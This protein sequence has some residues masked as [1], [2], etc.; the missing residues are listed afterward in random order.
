[1]FEIISMEMSL[2]P[3]LLSSLA[4]YLFFVVAL[5]I[6]VRWL[7]PRYT[8][9]RPFVSVVVAARNEE[10]SLPRLLDALIQQTYERFEVV[11]VN[12]RSTDKT[13]EIVRQYA[14][15]DS[16]ITLVNIEQRSQEMPPK[17]HAITQGILASR[18]E[19]LC[20]TDADCLPTREWVESLVRSFDDK[21]G[22]VVGYSLYDSHLTAIED[23]AIGLKGIL[24]RFLH[25]FVLYEAKKVAAL[26]AGSTGLG[27][28]WL[29]KASNLAYRKNVWEE[30]GGFE[31]LREVMSG[32][33]DL[34]LQ[35]VVRLT[36]WEVAHATSPESI[37][38]TAPVSTFTDFIAQRKRHFSVGTRYPIYIQALIALYHASNVALYASMI[39][40]VLS[41]DGVLLGIGAFGAKLFADSLLFLLATPQFR[42]RR[43]LPDVVFME[44]LYIPYILFVGPLG[45]VGKIEWKN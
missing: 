45:F 40:L 44:I 26:S 10:Y 19:I 14:V 27:L 34:F 9:R 33:D 24:Q 8:E 42:R 7:R 1:M 23:R 5:I 12:D 41:R 17:K 39:F 6:G 43:F 31:A 15:R 11:I 13:P 28:P 35:R 36:S 18:G 32:D 25:R 30:V 21:V 16:R 4:I 22:I 38:R 37:V 29:C 20:F 2:I 3:I